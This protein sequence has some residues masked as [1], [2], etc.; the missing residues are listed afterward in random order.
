MMPRPQ[1]RV[2]LA[3]AGLW[4][5][6]AVLGL[7]GAVLTVVAWRDLALSDSY[8]NLASA[9]AAVL[10]ASLGATIV[11]RVRNRM[12]WILLGVGLLLALLN[13]TSDYAIL[14]VQTYPGTLPVP[15]LVGA[16]SE[17]IFIPISMGVAYLLLLFPTGTLPSPRWRPFAVAG[18]VVAPLMLAAYVVSPRTVALP[19]P[20]GVSLLFPNPLAIRS[21]NPVVA[22]FGSISAVVVLYV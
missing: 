2:E 4:V 15:K 12:G 10:Y 9:L 19:A 5:S 18:A 13:L 7:A 3:S 22:G 16:M 6:T 11:L 20:G 8:P 17:W 21:V 1:G 14:G